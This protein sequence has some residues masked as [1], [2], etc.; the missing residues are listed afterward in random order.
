MHLPSGKGKQKIK[1]GFQHCAIAIRDFRKF[2]QG[3][4]RIFQQSDGKLLQ[5]KLLLCKAVEGS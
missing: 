5:R 2:H 1:D 4:F 3:T